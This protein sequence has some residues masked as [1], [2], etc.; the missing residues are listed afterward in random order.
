MGD[1]FIKKAIK[2]FKEG[3]DEEREK[4]NPNKDKSSKDQITEGTATG[5]TE[6]FAN[7]FSWL[8]A[9]WK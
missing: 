6:T 9:L 3:F 2:D 5:I 4:E 1:S 7:P 8:K